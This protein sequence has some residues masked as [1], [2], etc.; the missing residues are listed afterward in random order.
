MKKSY[1]KFYGRI[2][3]YEG[4]NKFVPDNND[5]YRKYMDN[6]TKPKQRYTFALLPYRKPRTTGSDANLAEGKGNQN[7]Y[8]WHVVIPILAEHFGL[9][10][11]QM[12]DELRLKFLPT[13]S[14]I[15]PNK[16][17]G[18]STKN[19]DRVQWED[20]MERI[21]IWA[22]TDDTINIKIPLP[23]EVVTDDEEDHDKPEDDEDVDDEV[24]IVDPI[25][26]LIELFKEVNPN[27]ERLYAN[28]NQRA[29]IDRMLKKMGQAQLEKIIKY[30]PTSNSNKF[31]PKITTPYILEAKLGDLIAWANTQKKAQHKVANLGK[32]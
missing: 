7:G 32:K 14:K 28:K 4:H 2:V 29:A 23:N 5:Y 16:I 15:D 25:N 1:P 12:H 19:L 22:I 27:Y 20:L 9:E 8:Y 30:L 21:R 17:M 6:N 11:W 10:L 3:F 31:A 13:V 26:P 18:G 24:K